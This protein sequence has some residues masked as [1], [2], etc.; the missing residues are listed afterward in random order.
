MAKAQVYTVTPI[1]LSQY[2]QEQV[3]AY[4]RNWANFFAGLSIPLRLIVRSEPFDPAPVLERIT[5]AQ[6]QAKARWR[7]EGLASHRR[8]I[9]ELVRQASLHSL[10]HQLILWP[11]SDEEG[12]GVASAFASRCGV[13]LTPDRVAP[14]LDGDYEAEINRLVPK[15]TRQP[16]A[17]L[18][19]S[20]DFVG[21]W[22]WA[23]LAGLLQ[24]PF[25]VAVALDVVTE[26]HGRV[27]D[28]LVMANNALEL[29]V[30]VG[31]VR[32][33]KSEAAWR[34]VNEAMQRVERGEGLHRVRVAVL[35]K[36]DTE[37]ELKGNLTLVRESVG[38]KVRMSTYLGIQAELARFFTDAPTSEIGVPN[39]S[40]NVL[41]GGVAVM[42]GVLGLSRRTRSEGT[43]W[44]LNLSGNYPIWR[45]GFGPKGIRPNHIV[46]VGETGGGKTVSMN[47]LCRRKALAGVQVIMLEPMGH[48]Q[49]LVQSVGN[50]GS[51]NPL[52]FDTMT[53]NPLDVMYLNLIDQ[54]TNVQTTLAIMLSRSLTNDEKAI[55]DAALRDLYRGIDP[56]GV[57]PHHVPRLE[58]LCRAL[59]EHG[60]VGGRLAAE[61][62]GMYVEGVL[63]RV[64][65]RPTNLDLSLSRDVVAFDFSAINDQY[66][67]L[68]YS[69]VLGRIFFHVTTRK[70]ERNRVVAIDE[71]KVM[72]R[73]PRLASQVAEMYKTFRTYGVGVWAAEQNLFTL[74]GLERG[75]SAGIDVASGRYILDN[76]QV[77][78]AF[79][80]QSAGA[81][82]IARLYD[83]MTP[84]HVQTMLGAQPGEA[85][86]K[87][88]E[89]IYHV[90]FGLARDEQAYFLGS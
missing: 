49:R 5:V 6:M 73:E 13:G 61:V 45:D 22:H 8:F 7:Q 20:H 12:R 69:Q 26:P 24:M 10:H 83:E 21:E 46:F 65:N 82:E 53:L 79:R 47:V 36:G 27:L 67:T 90:Y 63:G 31:K 37:D 88:E 80:Q 55:T 3:L 2:P 38:A 54:V 66:R 39:T 51:Y 32:D 58:N 81:K 28:R 16:Y 78:V 71:F 84:H 57:Q 4:V 40:R 60:E 89:G 30:R 70:R 19:L 68:L 50:G 74:T 14:A 56:R 43:F 18:L 41:S 52:S 17:T 77:L 35:V 75:S 85:V 72:S 48:S 64:F 59:G 23:V 76:S 86:V 44:G 87:F 15:S 25:P 33:P 1:D 34:D 42:G 29:T 9:E 62:A 11:S